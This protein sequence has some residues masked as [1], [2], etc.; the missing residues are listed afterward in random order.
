MTDVHKTL[1]HGTCGRQRSVLQTHKQRPRRVWIQPQ[2]EAH[3]RSGGVPF[4]PAVCGGVQRQDDVTVQS[5]GQFRK[6]IGL[7]T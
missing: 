1:T 7:K 6:K 2:G 3:D 5:R 4:E